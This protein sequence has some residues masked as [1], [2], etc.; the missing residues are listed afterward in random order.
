MNK[1]HSASGSLERNASFRQ[2]ES[3]ESGPSL[4]LGTL[5]YPAY[6]V[7]AN[8]EL[9]WWNEAACA[10]FLSSDQPLSPKISGRQIFSR[11]LKCEQIRNSLQRDDLLKSTLNL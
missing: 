7:N 4:T 8:F 3:S 11:L 5:E 1:V 6:F 9:E 2:V 10:A